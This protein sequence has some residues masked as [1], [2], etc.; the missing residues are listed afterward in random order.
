VKKYFIK[1]NIML[2]SFLHK[3]RD[4]KKQKRIIET[5]ISSLNISPEQKDLYF[6]AIK[7][8]NQQECENLY[9]NLIHFIEKVEL[10]EIEQIRKESF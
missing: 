1:N 10:K 5:M 8:M 3:Q 7:I 9:K 2:F 4:I 6:Q